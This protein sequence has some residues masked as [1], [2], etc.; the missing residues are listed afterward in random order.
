VG[1]FGG[2]VGVGV[3]GV[4]GCGVVW[5]GVVWCGLYLLGGSELEGGV[6]GTTATEPKEIRKQAS[7]VTKLW[8]IRSLPTAS[9]VDAWLCA[10]APVDVWSCACI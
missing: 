4:G 10:G 5:C 7:G 9:R 6:P 1:F 3:C 2:W 8:S